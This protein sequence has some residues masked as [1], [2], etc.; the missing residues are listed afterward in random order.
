MVR[1]GGEIPRGLDPE[2]RRGGKKSERRK[3]KHGDYNEFDNE[4]YGTIESRASG[5]G[6]RWE[7]ETVVYIGEVAGTARG[8]PEWKTRE[9]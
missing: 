2:T 3:N 8:R 6:P 1:R 7:D 9:I 4:L 5:C